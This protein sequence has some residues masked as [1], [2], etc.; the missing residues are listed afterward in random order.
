VDDLLET[1]F[2]D[3]SPF[4]KGRIYLATAAG[5]LFCICVALFVD[6]FNFASMPPDRLMRAIMINV[7]LPAA[8]AGPPIYFFMRK[9]R[10]L[11]VAHDR[12]ATLASTD[13]L[14]GVLNRGAL[15]AL[16]EQKLASDDSASVR[17]ALLILD[18]DNFKSINDSYGHEQGDIAL[19]LITDA[20]R[21][22]LRK[23][24]L[25]GRIGGEEFCVFLPGATQLTADAVGER[26]RHAVSVV[27]FLPGDR[28]HRLSVS[29]GGAV[30]DRRLPLSDLLRVADQQLYA[31]KQNGRNR[32]SVS[33]IVHYESVPAAAA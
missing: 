24:D 3:L 1:R 7:F 31:A 22:V 11:R 13:P 28:L 21:S 19:K 12:L 2:V 29:V 25:I 16:I 8:L 9:L 32:V 27:P 33:P 17:G 6:S 5:T 4:G 14:T 10:D 30:F 18:A 23:T 20:A 15:T 26:I